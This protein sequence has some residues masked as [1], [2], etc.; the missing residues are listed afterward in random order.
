MIK[1][2][3]LWEWK[4]YLFPELARREYRN[5]LPRDQQTCIEV[6]EV[7]RAYYRQKMDTRQEGE[8]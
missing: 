4:C 7:F 2:R 6:D 8:K 5:S 1:I 3:S